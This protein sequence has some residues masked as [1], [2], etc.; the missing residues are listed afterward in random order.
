MEKP[1]WPGSGGLVYLPRTERIGHM[2]T[3]PIGR[4]SGDVADWGE[5]SAS[6][7]LLQRSGTTTGPRFFTLLSN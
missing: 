1:T 5:V 6:I 4:L 3:L 7:L 2:S